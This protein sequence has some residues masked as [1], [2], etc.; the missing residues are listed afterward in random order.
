MSKMKTATL[1]TY[2]LPS[3]RMSQAEVTAFHRR[4]YGYTDYSNHGK[5]QYERKGLLSDIPHLN[6]SRSVIIIPKKESEKVL[7]FLE[8][9]G[10]KVFVIKVVLDKERNWKI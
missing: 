10:A 4:L 3:A 8:E 1:I 6:P 9:Y 2:D 7:G 5:Y